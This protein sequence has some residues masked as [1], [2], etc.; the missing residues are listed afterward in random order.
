[1]SVRG[2]L[3][4]TVEPVAADATTEQSPHCTSERDQG[5]AVTMLGEQLIPL[6]VGFFLTTVLG[7]GLGSYFQRRAWAHQHAVMRE[8]QE[9][10][11]AV[12]VFE[13]VSRLLDKRLYRTRLIYWPMARRD[14][15]SELP[16]SDVPWEE[17]RSVVCEWNDSINRNLALVQ[18][19]FGVGMRDTF[20][21]EI[22]DRLVRIGRQLEDIRTKRAPLPRDGFR[23]LG[24]ELDAVAIL[25][26]QFNLD[27]I[28]A[29]QAGKVG[30]LVTENR[31]ARR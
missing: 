5:E 4:D 14:G 23:D 31:P 21:Y 12:R 24:S 7:G 11:R 18:Q 10:E 17:Y 13:E 20:D 9:R 8:E 27:M 29:I 6:I 26:Y 19:Y 25:I 3:G 22:G 28:R 30:W 2:S 1:M 16:T 15:S